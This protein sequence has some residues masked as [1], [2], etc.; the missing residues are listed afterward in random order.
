MSTT[1]LK[2]LP[3]H[4]H[5]PSRGPLSSCGRALAHTKTFK[6]VVSK[7]FDLIDDSG[8]GLIDGAELYAG[9]LLVHLKLAKNAGPAACYPPT[10]VVVDRLFIKSDR[11]QSGRI[12]RLEF[13]YIVG[14]L[15][16]EILSRMFVF[17]IVMILCV[18][19]IATFVVDKAR[20]PR[21]T[22]LEKITREGISVGTFFL[23]IPLLW[24][25][26]DA[27]YSASSS[28]TSTSSSSD[29]VDSTLLPSRREDER[30]QRDARKSQL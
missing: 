26:I 29:S 22:Y 5:E 20:I 19:I 16:A 27:R 21:D 7:V 6:A 8:D 4:E 17:Y 10:R 9:I 11:D 24:N 28:S 23:A 15:C 14:V 30:K 25:M 1:N 3:A 12:D 13:H 2:P 18:P